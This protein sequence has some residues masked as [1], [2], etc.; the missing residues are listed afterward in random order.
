MRPPLGRIKHSNIMKR[1]IFFLTLVLSPYAS[2]ALWA[3]DQGN[4][5]QA[6]HEFCSAGI[7]NPSSPEVAAMIKYGDSFETNLNQGTLG[8]SIPIYTY[9]DDRFTIPVN[10][11]Y[12]TWGGY[13]PNIQAGPCGMGWSLSCGGTITREVRGIPD[14][15][16][17]TSTDLY[18]IHSLFYSGSDINDQTSTVFGWG[19]LHDSTYVHTLLPNGTDCNLSH[20]FRNFA[21]TGKAGA[22]YIPIWTFDDLPMYL[23]SGNLVDVPSYE[24]TP[25]VFHFSFMGRSGSF[26]LKP[27][28][29]I[30]VFGTEDSPK[31]YKIEAQLTA[32]GFDTFTIRTED[33][34]V[35]TFGG[36]SGRETSCS[37][38]T[39][40]TTDDVTLCCTWKLIGI[41]A[42]D[43]RTVSFIYGEP[44]T[45][46]TY[47]P[48]YTY[49]L[50]TLDT[51]AIPDGMEFP[52]DDQ[53]YHSNLFTQEVPTVSRVYS[54]LLTGIRVTGRAEIL[55]SYGDR[56]CESGVNVLNKKLDS[57]I[58]RSL[59][60]GDTV[61]TA[62][63]SY[64]LSGTPSA[65]PYPSSGYGVTFLRSVRIPGVGLYSMEYDSETAVFP[66]IDTYQVDWMGYYNGNNLQTPASSSFCPSETVLANASDLSW[67][68][69]IRCGNCQT[70]RMGL[71]T[72]MIYPTG[73]SSE[74]SYELNDYSTDLAYPLWIPSAADGY[75]V[76]LSSIFNRNADGAPV[77]TKTY[78]YINDDGRSSG[79][80][81]W[82]PT[83][84]SE[85]TVQAGTLHYLDIYHK[86]V[87]TADNFPYSRGYYME[88]SRVLEKTE[89]VAGT[90]YGRAITEYRYSS[91][92]DGGCK[93]TVG[94]W[95]SV[96]AFNHPW[97]WSYSVNNES[98]ANIRARTELPLYFQSRSG[99]KLL[100]RTEYSNDLY[101]PVKKTEHFY[102]TYFQSSVDTLAFDDI[103]YGL[104]MKYHVS[105]EDPWLECTLETDYSPEADSILTH[106][107]LSALDDD[108]RPGSIS[109]F[110]SRG[111]TLISHYHYFGP[112]PS[113]LTEI[114]SS[115][116]KNGQPVI[117]DGVKRTYN[118]MDTIGRFFIPVLIEVSDIGGLDTL[119]RTESVCTRWSV[120]GLPLETV[121]KSGIHT[122]ILWGYGGMYP[123]MTVSG[124]AYDYLVTSVPSFLDGVLT[125]S[126][127]QNLDAAVRSIPGAE[128][129]S[130]TWKPMVGVLS[131]KGP[132]GKKTSFEYDSF[133]RLATVRDNGGR[134]LT[135]NEYHILTDN[136]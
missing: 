12:S 64:H 100:S 125:G 120:G 84:Y 114:R 66:A 17:W 7:L 110:D 71:L 99:G 35:Y 118:P 40:A 128:V 59:H 60:T 127:P 61:R 82:R 55:F 94:E 45:S 109:S 106:T 26:I 101:H 32:G 10:L 112:C 21:Y 36:A 97:G 4:G 85:Y 58:V 124:M 57:V 37:F 111:D 95:E 102:N 78:Y 22:D 56:L 117:T 30:K 15:E 68:T 3:D 20:Y 47:T 98:P 123:L 6:M 122:S 133:G 48:T 29:H 62:S 132:S 39:L 93:D 121:D 108:Y 53:E 103:Q 24:T 88:Y 73:G 91:F 80:Q 27:Y 87:S 89:S 51:P 134:L 2:T 63:M 135:E 76:R 14:E 126:L 19:S 69:A 104:F 50:S 8:L 42:P 52:P 65:A 25:D 16:G 81:L 11:G 77:N 116:Q 113:L 130:W 83:L 70:S 74:F 13:R 92:S 9:S 96:H 136:L 46:F 86:T 72:R 44:E 79:T 115:R 107:V 23:A 38:N 90:V 34:Y 31:N 105:L 67:N 43:G 28:G 41:E 54:K 49:D 18:R 75:G 1:F 131:I 129:T 5:T 119:Y 33:N